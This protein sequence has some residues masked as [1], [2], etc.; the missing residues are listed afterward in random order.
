LDDNHTLLRGLV[1]CVQVIGEAAARM[2][3]QGRSR[4]SSLPWPKM[5][6][7]RHILVHVYYDIDADAVWRVVREHLPTLVTEVERVLAE[8]DRTA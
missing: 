3:E 5:A 2:S 8:W 4:A 1:Q 6:G 7:M